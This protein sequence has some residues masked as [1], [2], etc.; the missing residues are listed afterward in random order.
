MN[1]NQEF[2]KQMRQ[3]LL[4]NA[5]WVMLI[6]VASVVMGIVTTALITRLLSP[7][8]VG[9]YF[10]LFS[11]TFIAISLAKLGTE[12]AIVK[13]VAESIG[14][15]QPGRARDAIVWTFRICTAG[16]IA[17]GLL[18]IAGVELGAQVFQSETIAIRGQP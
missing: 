12:A 14:I 16:G 8:E 15:E 11:L 2:L 9:L 5:G 7:E 17:L 1:P 18:T 6:R 13:V 4:S 10:L 3:K